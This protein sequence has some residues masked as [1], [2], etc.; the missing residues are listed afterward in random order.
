MVGRWGGV[1]ESGRDKIVD[2]IV[3]E[4][5]CFAVRV[6]VNTANPIGVQSSTQGVVSV[7]VTGSIEADGSLV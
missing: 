7:E 2:N 3:D 4:Y 1:I 6:S 5:N